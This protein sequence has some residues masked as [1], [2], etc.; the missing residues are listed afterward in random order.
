MAYRIWHPL[1]EGTKKDKEIGKKQK[2]C[3]FND[4]QKYLTPILLSALRILKYLFISYEHCVKL[5]I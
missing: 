1:R 4:T 5:K 2:L 3:L